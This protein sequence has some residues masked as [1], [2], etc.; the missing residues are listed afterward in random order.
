MMLTSKVTFNPY[1]LGTLMKHQIVGN[2]N[3]I[4]IVAM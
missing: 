2:L 1:M 4:V 3:T